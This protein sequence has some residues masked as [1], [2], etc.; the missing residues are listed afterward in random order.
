MALPT[1][2][3]PLP[4]THLTAMTHTQY[5][6]CDTAPPHLPPI[7]SSPNLLTPPSASASASASTSASA[8]PRLASLLPG[9]PSRAVLAV[10]QQLAEADSAAGREEQPQGSCV[11]CVCGG[12]GAGG[13]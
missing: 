9:A 12:G 8:S 3:Y 5:A 7:S 13:V 1:T 6:N 11:V 10:L 4:T 2:H